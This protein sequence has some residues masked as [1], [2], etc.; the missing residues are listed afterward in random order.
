MTATDYLEG[1]LLDHAC[2]VNPYTMPSSLYLC[3]HYND[4]TESGAAPNQVVGGGYAPQ[5]ITFGTQVNSVSS[6]TNSQTFSNMPAVTV[7]HFVIRE[8]SPTGNPCFVGILS[9]N[10]TVSVGDPVTFGV[11]QIAIS[12]D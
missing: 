7:S 3:L 10:R 9:T 12:A 11:G 2:G 8:N 4:P 1:R 6:S 5:L